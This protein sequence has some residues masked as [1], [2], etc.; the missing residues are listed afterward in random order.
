MVRLLQ[1]GKIRRCRSCAFEKSSGNLRRDSRLQSRPTAKCGLSSFTSSSF[2][3]PPVPLLTLSSIRLV[4]LSFSRQLTSKPR[5]NCPRFARWMENAPDCL[6]LRHTGRSRSSARGNPLK[7]F[8]YLAC[9]CT[10]RN[11]PKRRRRRLLIRHTQAFAQVATI[12][13]R[14][15]ARKLDSDS[16]TLSYYRLGVTWTRRNR[17]EFPCHNGTIRNFRWRGHARSR[18]SKRERKWYR[19]PSAS[20]PACLPIH[21]TSLTRA[22]HLIAVSPVSLENDA[23]R[24]PTVRS[25]WCP[26]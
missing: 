11:M 22:L 16:V 2:S 5:V 18:V 7:R 9:T 13:P 21:F 26:G 10:A 19:R 14:D 3:L 25:T 20:R 12:R 15:Y 17:A 1:R 8:D 23:H 4:F 6:A 24:R